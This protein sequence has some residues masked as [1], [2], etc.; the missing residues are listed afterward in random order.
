MYIHAFLIL[1]NSKERSKESVLAHSKT[2]A[3][4]VIA[5]NEF[6]LFFCTG[7]FRLGMYV[8]AFAYK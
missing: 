6:N 4:N 3:K 1:S 2:A 8:Y 7:K 5:E